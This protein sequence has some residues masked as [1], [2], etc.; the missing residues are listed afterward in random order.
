MLRYASVEVSYVRS[1]SSNNAY[2]NE[3]APSFVHSKT[4]IG[5]NDAVCILGPCLDVALDKLK[6]VQG[7][8]CNNGA[9][10]A[11]V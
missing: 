1:V 5:G 7:I 6:Y 8:T 4:M 2:S 9:E 10:F 3:H 11:I